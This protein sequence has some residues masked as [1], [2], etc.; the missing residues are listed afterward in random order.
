MAETGSSGG[1]EEKARSGQRI[2]VVGANHL[3]SGLGLRD[4]LYVD[5]NDA[6]GFLDRLKA[7][8]IDQ[9]LVLSTCDRVEVHAAVSSGLAA[10]ALIRGELARHGQVAPAEMEDQVYTLEGPDA[11]A[12][13]F[14]VA[15]SLGSQV[16]GETQVL[17]QVKAAHRV[18]LEHAMT[19]S[20]LENL[21]QGA[22]AAAK[23]VRAETKIGERPVSIAAAA[24][25]VARDLHGDLD[26]S[27]GLLIG[28]GDMGVFI[29]RDLLSQGLSDLSVTHPTR[30]RADH[31]A[32]ALETSVLDFDDLE[33]ALVKADIVVTALGARKRTL[34][35][36][37]L[38]AALKARRQKPLFVVDVG[39]PGDVE[40]G[41]D[42]LNSAFLY[43]LGDLESVAMEGK[44]FR[45]SEAIGARAILEEEI[46]GY[47]RGQAERTA[48]PSL[49]WLRDRFEDARVQALKDAG[50][51]ADRATQ[52]LVNRLLHDPA[53]AMRK[54]AG[55]AAI[56]KDTDDADWQ[57]F[58]TALRRLFSGDDPE[59][60]S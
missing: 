54:S 58:E 53:K 21:L 45:E 28:G 59:K 2:V 11:V 42:D 23:R 41:V 57:S 35:V 9:A 30:R 6:P 36:E 18:S 55:D 46:A 47:L 1:Q 22:Y 51:D 32:R 50:G 37:R 29:A 17:G 16:I 44:A 39:V 12:H 38:K 13:I 19:G 8:G 20:A 25:Q 33:Q 14:T 52:L 49:T 34:T 56:N 3:S 7:K 26:R 60:N 48:V 5:E 4:R 31:V 43:T 24:T 10:D 40:P 15:G 27:R